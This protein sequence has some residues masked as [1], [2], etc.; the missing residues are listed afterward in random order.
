MLRDPIPGLDLPELTIEPEASVPATSYEPEPEAFSTEPSAFTFETGAFEVNG[1]ETDGGLDGAG[2]L[3]GEVEVEE[4]GTTD[5]GAPADPWGPGSWGEVSAFSDAD[6]FT[7]ADDAAA[8]NFPSEGLPVIGQ[9][10][11]HQDLHE[12]V[13]EPEPAADDAMTAFFEQDDESHG[14]RFGRRR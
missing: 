10:R 8:A 13:N 12:A 9:D 5:E 14:R 2:S 7:P 1:T 4:V 6:A 11:Y 3:F